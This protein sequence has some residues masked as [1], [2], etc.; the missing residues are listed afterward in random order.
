MSPFSSSGLNAP[1][2][3]TDGTPGHSVQRD[4]YS[5]RCAAHLPF[6][7]MASRA[8]WASVCPSSGLPG[9]L[10]CIP[11]WCCFVPGP[12]PKSC[13]QTCCNT[14]VPCPEPQ[15]CPRSHGVLSVSDL[16]VQSVV[17]QSLPDENDASHKV[18]LGAVE[19]LPLQ[20]P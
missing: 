17:P 11:L 19:G 12:G 2:W 13:G 4:F 20:Q 14:E 10:P 16:I 5:P 15:P 7:P 8:P 9:A 6:V 3:S 1:W 18:N